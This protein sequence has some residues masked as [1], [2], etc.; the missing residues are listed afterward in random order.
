MQKT[1][2]FRVFFLLTLVFFQGLLFAQAGRGS[3]ISFEFIDQPIRDILFS[4]STYARISIIADDT[5]TG[6]ASF[7]FSGTDFEKAFDTFLFANRLY[8]EK[9]PA[10]WIV[11]R[12]Q[13]SVTDGIITLDTMDASPSQIL[14]KLSQKLSATV[15]QDILPS[16]KLSIHLNTASLREAVELVM[17]PFT[18]YAVEELNTYI[19]VR[20]LP[21][22]PFLT[23]SSV[24]A[25]VVNIRENGGRYDVSAEHARLGDILDQLFA[26]GQ[27]EYSSFI[28]ADQMIERVRF[29]G[30]EFNET[31][32]MI[33]EQGNGE[34]REINGIWYI[35]PLAQNDI[36]SVLKNDGKTWRRFEIKYR[37]LNEFMPL[38]QSRFPSLQTIAMSDSINFLALIGED[39]TIELQN[40]IRTMDT[41]RHTEP[42]KL[43]YIRT[44][45]LFKALPP[46][47]RREELV[48]AGNGNAFF[49]SGTPERLELFLKDLEIIDR[50]QPRIRY[51][52]FIIQ[53]QETSGLDW[54]VS[55]ELRELRPGDTTMVTGQLGNLL[56]L[57]FDV[58]TVFG[59]Q[60]AAK[61]NAAI[62]ENQ[63]S[64]FADTT[65]FGLSGQ[66]IKFQNTNTYRYRD[67]NIDPD[68]GKPIYS[69]VTREITSGLV[70]NINGWV[71]GDGMITTS[72]TAEVS[73]RGAD[74]SSSAGNPPPTSEKILTTQV[75][76]RSGETVVLSGLRQNDSTIVEERVPF[77]SKIPILGWLF[78]SRNTTNEKTQ[79]VIYLGPHVDLTNDEYTVEG[80]KTASIY[81]RFVEPFME[82]LP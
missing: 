73:K 79:M 6:T 74:V 12:I 35:F 72:I 61:I 41:P 80:L 3:L 66:E 15:I 71:S 81:S 67:S 42:I 31:L 57:N 77:I 38:L 36:I 24:T 32:A 53:V 34:Y 45:D 33:L 65:L 11:S 48:D 63:A 44:E 17:R 76:S 9:Q 55:A 8:A 69:G 39:D 54:N 58:I 27:Q 22:T 16:T 26:Y 68:T 23:A 46:S 10:L 7:Q 82:A 49:F 25:G 30:K 60:F 40:Y 78:K 47:V 70:L 59:H 50:P 52:L 4:F 51:D 64:V 19:M 75:R 14:E 13:L 43:K 20:K 37:P 18:E 5:V 2:K 62:S 28:R 21:A 1:T 29:S 56:N